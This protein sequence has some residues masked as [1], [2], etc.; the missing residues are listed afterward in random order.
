MSE[1][2][3]T[4]DIKD[5]ISFISELGLD[6]VKI[7]TEDLTLEIK[8]NV[9][10]NVQYIEQ[11]P[12]QHQQAMQMVE[13]VAQNTQKNAPQAKEESP[14]SNSKV[15]EITS[16]MIGTFYRSASPEAAPFVNVGDKIKKGQTVCIVEAMKLFNEIEAEVSGTVVKV[17]AENASPVEYGNV[18]FLVELD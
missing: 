2:M 9:V 13:Q 15:V 3:K 17:L 1:N 18:L 7:K 10:Q 14:V 5:L 4:K 12:V 8:R 6:E 11:R 16:P